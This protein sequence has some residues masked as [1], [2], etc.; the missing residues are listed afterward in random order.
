[1]GLEQIADHVYHTD[2]LIMGGGV[3]GCP[4]AVK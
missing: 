2:V 3:A 4:A 1:M